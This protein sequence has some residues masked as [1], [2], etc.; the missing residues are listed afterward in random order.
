MILPNH[1][2]ILFPLETY[3]REIDFRLALAVFLLRP[4]RQILL[5]NHTDIY[6]LSTMLRQTVYVGKSLHCVSPTRQRECY[7]HAKQAGTKVIYLHEEGGVYEDDAAQ[8][9][10]GLFSRLEPDWL[11]ADDY[12][13]AWGDVQAQVYQD[14]KP[15]FSKHIH[16]TG[17]PRF[18]LCKDRFAALYDHEVAQLRAKYG[19]FVLINTNFSHFSHIGGNGCYFGPPWT[20]EN[21]KARR[22]FASDYLAYDA[23]Q[24]STFIQLIDHL[25][26]NLPDLNI[27]LRPHPSEETR[28]YSDIFKHFERV[29][30]V[31]EGSLNAWLRACHTL[32]HSGCTTGIE[33]SLSGA[34]VISYDPQGYTPFTKRISNLA[35]RPACT[36]QEVLDFIRDESWRGGIEN[37]PPDA[38]KELGGLFANFKEGQDSF[39]SLVRVIED[40]LENTLP[41]QEETSVASFVLKGRFQRLKSS[42]RSLLPPALQFKSKN[43]V[44]ARQKFSGFDLTQLNQ[45]LALLSRILGGNI[46]ITRINNMVVSLT[47]GD[48]TNEINPHT[49]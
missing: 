7:D 47:N 11:G 15:A 8:I 33:G 28:F 44:H 6:R 5:G 41:S 13:C 2:I 9:K 38:R 24:F 19:R 21:D 30:V 29:H 34:R 1:K 22:K 40:C 17:H 16:V 20:P 39:A 46:K 18:D 14:A 42:L 26:T 25:E 3:V 31:R 37:L 32:I 27:V 48:A 10:Y 23:Q 36:Q 43:N 49:A 45:K 12:F 35:G 4:G